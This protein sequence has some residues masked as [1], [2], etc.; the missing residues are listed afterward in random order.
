MAR[1]EYLD[2]VIAEQAMVEADLQNWSAPAKKRRRA[3][4][5]AQVQGGAPPLPPDD[6][7]DDAGGALGVRVTGW[8]RFKNVIVPPNA[9]VVHTRR[10]RPEPLHMGLG[11]SFA[12]DP[13]RDAYI[14][15]PATMQTI[16]VSAN[17]ICAERQG[18]VVQGYVQ[19]IVDDFPTAYRRLDFSDADDPMRV[20]NVQLREQAEATIKDTVA[21]MSIDQVLADKQPIIE[22]LTRRLRDVVESGGREGSGLG[23]RIVTVQIKEAIVSSQTLWETLQ[24]PFRAERHKVARLAEL[25]HEA[26]VHKHEAAAQRDRTEREITTEAEIARQRAAAERAEQEA[27]IADEQALDARRAEAEAE[28]FDREQQELVR[29][30]Q[31]EAQGSAERAEAEQRR[32]ENMAAVDRLQLEQE[33][34]LRQQRF[35]ADSA[36]RERTIA[37][38]AKAQQVANDL[39]ATHVQAQLIGMLPELAER[40]PAPAEQRTFTFGSPDALSGLIDGLRGLLSRT[41]PAPEADAPDGSTADRA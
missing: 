11:I 28:T 12:F 27:Q 31:V 17:C 32:L 8:W 34:E 38:D 25:E 29:R 21:T 35:D 33:L 4:V 18:I 19:W 41:K 3:E 37:L 2:Q 23:L 30:A 9:Y 6:S 24:T 22:E 20:V 10:G 26:E 14:V 5:Q 39:S 1:N 36:E 15:V 13:A 7:R 40:L 16:V